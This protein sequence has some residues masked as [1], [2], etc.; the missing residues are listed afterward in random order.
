MCGLLATIGVLVALGSRVSVAM[1]PQEVP[2]EVNSCKAIT[3]D[4]ERLRC[5]NGLFG[6]TPKP[7]NPPEK[8][9]ANWSIDETKSPTQS[10]GCRGEPR[11]RHRTHSAM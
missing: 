6:E 10:S 9:Q 3:D 7:Q 11:R 1:S 4:K 5:F 8:A 2:A